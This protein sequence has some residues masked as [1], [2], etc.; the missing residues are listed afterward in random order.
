MNKADVDIAALVRQVV[1][2]TLGQEAPDTAV[3]PATRSQP[4]Q[5]PIIDADTIKNMPA[6]TRQPIPANAI[7]TPLAQQAAL[8]RS[9]QLEQQS[10]TP[11]LHTSAAPETAVSGSVIAIG[12]DHGGFHMKEALKK[13]LET[14]YTI[15]DCGTHSTESVDYPDYAYA[16]AQLVA[17][18]KAWRGIMIDGAG[19][20]SCMT[21]NK[22]PGVRAAMCYDQATAVNSREHNNANVLTLGAGL[23]GQNLANQIVTTWLNTEFGGGRHAR[24]VNKIDAIGKRFSK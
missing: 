23:I 3:S 12:A 16:V 6:N 4:T 8:E 10:V 7:V 20:G 15:I 21:A 1:M 9:I 11:T 17:S 22:V 18:G 19:I 2:R 13:L 24:R 14:D 5:R